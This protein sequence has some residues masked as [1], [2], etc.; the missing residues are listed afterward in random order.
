VNVGQPVEAGDITIGKV[1]AVDDP[2]HRKYHKFPEFGHAKPQA[3]IGRPHSVSVGSEAALNPVSLTQE[4]LVPLFKEHLVQALN[5]TSFD[6][7]LRLY[8]A[9]VSM[10]AV[11]HAISV[12]YNIDVAVVSQP[13]TT[14]A[15]TVG[16]AFDDGFDEGFAY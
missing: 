8:P 1:F 15:P 6:L 11:A 7:Y 2:T 10:V 14:Y 3:A 12:I 13:A 16:Y 9:L 5:P 4:L